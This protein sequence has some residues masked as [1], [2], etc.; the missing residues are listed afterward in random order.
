MNNETYRQWHGVI[1]SRAL[2]SRI[3][4]LLGGQKLLAFGLDPSCLL[5][6]L[7]GSS[8]RKKERVARR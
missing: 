2:P 4:R 3:Y 8:H 7:F 1:H 6:G 5:G